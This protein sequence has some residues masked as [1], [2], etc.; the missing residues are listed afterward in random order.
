LLPFVV[1]VGAPLWVSHGC[2]A[3]AS[4]V[5]RSSAQPGCGAAPSAGKQPITRR[6]VPLPSSGGFIWKNFQRGSSARLSSRLRRTSTSPVSASTSAV[7][8]SGR[9]PLST[10][11]ASKARRAGAP[12][13]GSA[14]IRAR[15]GS[16]TPATPK[17][18]QPCST[19][20][21]P[22]PPALTSRPAV[23]A[24]RSHASWAVRV[25]APVIPL[26]APSDDET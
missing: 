10:T 9:L 20:R 24:A 4:V 5:R 19:R 11:A 13:T 21:S 3:A 17:R 7:K 23:R 1:N 15:P 2:G 18:A 8:A 6:S 16:V 26:S 12:G 22:R 25:C 14:T